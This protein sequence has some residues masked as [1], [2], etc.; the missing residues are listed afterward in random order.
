MNNFF[1]HDSNARNDDKILALRMKHGWEGYGLFWAIVEKLRDS[2]TYTCVRDYNLVAYD[3][4]CDA[5]KAKSIIEDFGLFAFTENGECFYSESLMKRMSIKDDISRKCSE[6]GRKSAIVRG[7]K[8][9]ETNTC[10]TSVQQVLNNKSKVK[11]S[12]VNKENN[13]SDEELQKKDENPPSPPP[14]DPVKNQSQDT[15][16]QAPPPTPSPER[17]TPQPPSNFGLLPVREAAEA[18]MNEP[19]WVE[20]IRMKHKLSVGGLRQNIEEFIPHCCSRGKEKDSLMGFKQHFD[21]WMDKKR[22]FGENGQ[23]GAQ[24][25]RYEKLTQTRNEALKM[26]GID[27]D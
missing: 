2:S 13:S 6:A 20:N 24:K 8:P 23:N 10:S 25:G 19:I 22:Q 9:K 16:S 27:D 7:C 26:L 18:A 14:D 15:E 17:S 3:L 21:S 4:R 11:E 5:A 12:K 1:S